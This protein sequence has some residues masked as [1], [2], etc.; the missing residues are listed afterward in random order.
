M[1]EQRLELCV[2][3]DQPT[4]R[5]GAAEDSLY[6]EDGTGPYCPGCFSICSDA[7]DSEPKTYDVLV[8]WWDED[9]ALYELKGVSEEDFTLLKSF[10]GVYV[11]AGSDEE[12]WDKIEDYFLDPETSKIPKQPKA[13]GPILNAKYDAVVLTGMVP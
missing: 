13:D 10:N 2:T 4:G 1:L 8:V 6:L 7:P 9:V 3:C 5:V 11:N 12:I